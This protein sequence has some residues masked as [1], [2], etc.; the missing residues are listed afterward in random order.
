MSFALPPNSMAWLKIFGISSGRFSVD[1]AV[2]ASKYQLLAGSRGVDRIAES[3]AG[4]TM[5]GSFILC[6]DEDVVS[7]SLSLSLSLSIGNLVG[8]SLRIDPNDA[9]DEL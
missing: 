3:K 9:D 6:V 2:A 8:V 5:D 4:V 7:L 1:R